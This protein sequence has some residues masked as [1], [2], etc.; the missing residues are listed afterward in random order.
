MVCHMVK[1]ILFFFS[2]VRINLTDSGDAIAGFED[3]TL[4]CNAESPTPA[5]FTSFSW[6]NSEGIVTSDDRIN[7]TLLNATYDD[8]NEVFV[9]NSTLQFRTLVPSDADNWTCSITLD[10]T[11]AGIN[12]TNSSSIPIAIEGQF[13]NQWCKL[14]GVLIYIIVYLP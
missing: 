1:L 12:Y 4:Y 6:S 5:N 8:F 10:L 2:P 9:F 3:Y 14:S 13:V 11:L 7:I